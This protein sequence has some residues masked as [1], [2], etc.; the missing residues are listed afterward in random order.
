MD[1][2]KPHEVSWWT[3]TADG[4]ANL[5][6]SATSGLAAVAMHV[7]AALGHGFTAIDLDEINFR[8]A[9]AGLPVANT[10]FAIAEK[11]ID[12]DGSVASG[13]EV[14]GGLRSEGG[15]GGVVVVALNSRCGRDLDPLRRGFELAERRRAALEVVGCFHDPAWLRG[16]ATSAGAGLTAESD[17]S[18]EL[19]GLE[20]FLAA[21][22]R[23]APGSVPVRTRILIGN[24][25]RTL[26]R[27]VKAT[28]CD[29][30]ILPKSAW[31]PN[32]LIVRWRLKRLTTVE[33][34]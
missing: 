28:Q 22:P 27:L 10:V 16:L 21:V 12:K 2:L 15:A 34:R 30:I 6:S 32:G 26:A 13:P 19:K 20:R 1:E 9:A 5:M 23:D 31:N 17:A 18:K 33:V 4:H 24:P 8:R 14:L 3:P 25:H 11:V 7:R 29:L